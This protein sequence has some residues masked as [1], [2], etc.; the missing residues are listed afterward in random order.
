MHREH[1]QKRERK[2]K[3]IGPSPY[4]KNARSVASQASATAPV[5]LLPRS[6][7]GVDVL[8]ICYERS[9]MN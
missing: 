6:L 4:V 2:L 3:V 1:K 5:G 7:T 8:T 9:L